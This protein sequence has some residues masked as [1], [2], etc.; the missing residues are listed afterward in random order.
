MMAGH[1]KR[2]WDCCLAVRLVRVRSGPDCQGSYHDPRT[3]S[4]KHC[5]RKEEARVPYGGLVGGPIWTHADHL[6]S[7]LRGMLTLGVYERMLSS[8]ISI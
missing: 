4:C 6:G 1:M 5:I 2:T 7:Y 8:L 3:H